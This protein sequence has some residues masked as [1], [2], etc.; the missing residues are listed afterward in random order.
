MRFLILRILTHSEL[1]MFHEYRRQGKEG[2]KQRAVNFDWDVVDRVFPAAKDSDRIEMELRYDTDCGV[3]TVRQ[4]LKRQDKNWRLEGNCPRDKRYHF[5]EPGCLFAMEVEGGATPALGAWAVFSADDKVTKAILANGESCRL[6]MSSMIA[7]HDEEGERSWQI[8]C[9]ARPDLFS[10]AKKGGT[11]LTSVMKTGG[12]GVAL[13][14]NPARLVKILASVGHTMPSAVAD[15]VDNAIS[16]DA[17]EIAITLGRPDAGHG[18]WMSLADNG[19]GMDEITLA[20]AMRI[21]SDSDYEDNSLGKYG[22]GLKG[23]S[24]SQA[25]VFTVVTKREGALAHHLT[26]DINNMDGWVAKSDPLESWEQDATSL[27]KSGTVVLWKDMRPPQ[28]MLVS[29]GLDPHSCELMVLERHLALV[30][31]RFLE[32]KAAGRKKVTITINGNKVEPNNPVG[33]PLTSTYDAKTVRIPT[34]FE[35]GKVLVQAY[36]LPTE[37]ELAEHHQGESADLARRARDLISL[38]GNWNDSQ[39]LFI[40]RHDRLIKWGGW[41][42]MWKTNDE[43]TKLARVVISFDKALDDVF[44]INISKMLVQLPMQLQTEIKALA[45]VARK[46]SQKKYRKPRKLPTESTLPFLPGGVRAGIS[47]GTGNGAVATPAP[48]VTSINPVSARPAP[49]Q[50]I[51][52]KEVRTDKF[53]WKVTKGMT[54]EIDIQVSELNPSLSCLLKEIES[55]PQAMSHLVNFLVGLDEAEVQKHLLAKRD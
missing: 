18:R 43:K 45:D 6:V 29:R 14:P 48:T 44:K 1:G 37:D 31:H 55:A 36:L 41:H 54:G 24:W 7:L 11:M 2:S 28:T 39:G 5:V 23:A 42:Q 52:V 40:Y 51:G 32:G 30:F 4:W 33:H 38:H 34:E 12:N 20:E 35:D 47:D 15:L 17:T 22:Y 53:V 46:D 8:L 26:W 19:C 25:K 10:M 21:G 16:A 3:R 13:P 49:L 50:R 27:G 9:Q